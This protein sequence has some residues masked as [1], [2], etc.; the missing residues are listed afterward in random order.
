MIGRTTQIKELNQL[1][2]SGKAELVAVY[3]RRRVGK[4]FLINETFEGRFAFKHAGLSPIEADDNTGAMK[5]QLK[6]FYFSLKNY[7]VKKS[8]CPESWFEAFFMLEQLLMSRDNGSRQVV[9]LDELPWL[10][11]PRSNFITAFEGFWNN[12]AC[13]RK[14]LMVIVCGS[15]TSWILDSLLNNHG[16][17]YNRVTYE[18]KLS[19]FTLKECEDFF[20]A[21]KVRISKYDIVQSYMILG[22]V[23]YYLGYFQRDKSFAQNIDNMF[24]APD[25]KL[26]DE[27]DRLFAS[28]FKN[29]TLMKSIVKA[30]NTNNSGLTRSEI[31]Q[32]LKIKDGETMQLAL[33]ALIV[34]N[35]VTKYVPFGQKKKDVRYKLI[36]Q[37]CKF[38]LKFLADQTSLPENFWQ[39]NSLSPQIVA[40][41]GFAFE[42]V[43]FNHIKQ[44]KRALGI[45]GLTTV[46]SAWVS[47]A[48]DDDSGTQ[49]DMI[50]ERK[51]NVVEMCEIKFYS[52][53]FAV[54]KDYHEILMHR[55]ELLTKKISSKSVIHSTL[56]TT[57]GL[58]NNEYSDDFMSV[59]TMEGLFGA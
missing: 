32:Y 21:N 2:N 35:F 4:T 31:T 26:R 39:E 14:N 49:I 19:P 55:V 23:P 56:I 48:S 33:N 10:D 44:I 13:A 8:K 57:Y 28:V 37:F 5:N 24:F 46:Q 11:T 38:Y 3:G 50:I 12:W 1:Y 59:V 20:K 40:W 36:D 52:N 47:P 9:F 45:S 54:N 58:K 53:K 17:L 27:Y 7:G 34:S 41:R 29:P 30:L 42:S 51:D 43:C 16:G 15:A 18:I 25:A 22:G 6:Q